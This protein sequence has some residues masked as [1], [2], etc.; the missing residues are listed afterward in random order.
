MSGGNSFMQPAYCARTSR[1]DSLAAGSAS[2]VTVTRAPSGRG[3]FASRT[4]APF[5]TVPESVIPFASRKRAKED[6]TL[7]RNMDYLGCRT[8]SPL[9]PVA[10]LLQKVRHVGPQ[11]L[12][13]GAFGFGQLVQRG[14][15]AHA[16]QVGILLPVPQFL[17]HGRPYLRLAA[18]RLLTP[19][20]QVGPQPVERLL[21]QEG[22]IFVV[23]LVGAFSL[24]G[25][26]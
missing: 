14:R 6:Y 17:L 21:T 26:G 24:S 1:N 10:G 8:A 22:A 4:M 23:Q 7:G 12:P 18:F 11:L 16:G 15:V 25:D 5:T 19:Q 20:G 2:I 3:C 9:F 13:F